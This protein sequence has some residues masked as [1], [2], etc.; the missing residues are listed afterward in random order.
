MGN[1]VDYAMAD[2]RQLTI[3]LDLAGAH[4]GTGQLL[5]RASIRGIRDAPPIFCLSPN[6][7]AAD[8][9][10]P[11]RP[12]RAVTEPYSR[13]ICAGKNTY[14]YDAHTYHTKVPPEGIALLIDY[15]TN[16]GGVVLDPFCGSGMTGV[17]ASDRGRSAILSDLSPAAAF[18]AYNLNTPIEERRYLDA[19]RA[20]LAASKDLER[21]LYVTHC[22]TCARPIPML[23]TVWSYGMRC[24][25]CHEEV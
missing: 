20:I 3:R 23:Y 4:G 8:L 24:S 10:T 6:P 18:I 11:D 25:R 2:G 13:G 15:Y 17:A 9:V 21:E 19:V 1:D 16:P 14:V 12:A 22:R 7:Y 5:P